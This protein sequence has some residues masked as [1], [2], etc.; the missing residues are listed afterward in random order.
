[1][2]GCFGTDALPTS[3]F[4]VVLA[5]YP[6]IRYERARILDCCLAVFFVLFAS[7]IFLK[8][9]PMFFGLGINRYSNG[10]GNA[11]PCTATPIL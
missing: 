10:H 11:Q 6:F 9:V 5:W 4:G 2:C 3:S 7:L 8:N 1:M